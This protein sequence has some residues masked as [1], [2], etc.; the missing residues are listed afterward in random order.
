LSLVNDPQSQFGGSAAE[1]Q[2]VEV[3][4]VVLSMNRGAAT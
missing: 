4:S 2:K 1:K 3:G